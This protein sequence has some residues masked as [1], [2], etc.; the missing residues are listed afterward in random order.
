MMKGSPANT[1]ISLSAKPAPIFGAD[2]AGHASIAPEVSL[3]TQG[4]TI[5]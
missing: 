5:S 3:Q 2:G 4:H 1:T